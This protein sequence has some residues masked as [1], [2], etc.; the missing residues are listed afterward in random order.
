MAAKTEIYS[1]RVSPALKVGLE[2]KARA[3]RRT[4]AQLLDEIVAEHLQAAGS[5]GGEEARQ[6]RL[7][8]HA[9][10][11]AGRLSGSDPDRAARAREL[12]RV[13]L[14]RASCAR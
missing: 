14:R 11:F 5:G 8:A 6:R 1:W 13:R 10:R 4:V 7:H 3:E 9:A 12:V 2:E